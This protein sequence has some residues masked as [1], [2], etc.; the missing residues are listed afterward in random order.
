M[1]SQ[2]AI[3]GT[4]GILAGLTTAIV[5][6]IKQMLPKTVPTKIVTII[7][8]FLVTTVYV[9]MTATAII[10]MTIVYASAESFIVAY[11]AMF[12]FDSLKDIFKRFQLDK[13]DEE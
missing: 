1:I 8:A 13:E 12:G 10:P 7:V 4:L 9:F 11:L 2:T 5:E 6:V 3:L